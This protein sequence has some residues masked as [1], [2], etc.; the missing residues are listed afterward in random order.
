MAAEFS[1]AARTCVCAWRLCVCVWKQKSGQ[2]GEKGSRAGVEL[3]RSLPGIESCFSG[4]CGPRP[5]PSSSLFDFLREEEGWCSVSDRFY[6]NFE[7]RFKNIIIIIGYEENIAGIEFRFFFF[8]FI[9][10]KGIMVNP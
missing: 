4:F 7:A 6:S 3:V 8:F 10:R 1:A 5:V 2:P 9:T